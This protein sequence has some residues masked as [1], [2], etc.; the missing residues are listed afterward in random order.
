MNLFLTNIYHTKK[1]LHKLCIRS[2]CLN[3]MCCILRKRPKK[4]F[5]LRY[6]S[7]VSLEFECD[8]HDEYSI[9]T[10]FIYKHLC[11]SNSPNGIRFSF[12]YEAS[13]P[14]TLPKISKNSQNCLL[15]AINVFCAIYLISKIVFIHFK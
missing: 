8:F 10:L 1:L 12:I 9:Q 4:L 15:H 13:Q 11:T 6:H 14:Q 7:T 5:P 3:K 2:Y